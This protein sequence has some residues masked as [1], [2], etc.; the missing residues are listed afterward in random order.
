MR[1]KEIEGIEADIVFRS[2]NNPDIKREHLFEYISNMNKVELIDYIQNISNQ[3]NGIFV[4][5]ENLKK[6]LEILANRN[7]RQYESNNK[8]LGALEFSN[9]GTWELDIETKII[10]LSDISSRIYG[11]KNPVN[12]LTI[13]QA[14]ELVNPQDKYENYVHLTNLIDNDIPYLRDFRIT[15]VSD[16]NERWIRAKGGLIRNLSGKPEKVIGTL[17]DIT[18]S[19]LL[20]HALEES[21]ERH[22]IISELTSDFIYSINNFDSDNPEFEW[23]NKGL[24][25]IYGY[26]KTDLESVGNLEKIVVNHDKEIYR[27][28]FRILNNGKETV[29]EYRVLDNSG[30]LRWVRDYSKPVYNSSENKIVKVIGAIQDITKMKQAEQAIRD[31]HLRLR[32]IFD[33]IPGSICVVD[34]DTII[35]DVN[36]NFLSMQGFNFRNDLIGKKFRDVFRSQM[37]DTELL[38]LEEVINTGNPVTRISV[39]NE[40]IGNCCTY[41]IYTNPVV[42]DFNQV[43]GA[44]KVYTD[45]SDMKTVETKLIKLIDELSE[46]KRTIETQ[47]KEINLINSQLIDSQDRLKQLNSDKDKLFSIIAHDLRNPISSFLN[48]TYFLFTEHE[49][50]SV[51]EIKDLTENLHSSA[52]YLNKLLEN[53]LDWS[54]AQTGGIEFKPVCFNLNEIIFDNLFLFKKAAEEKNIVIAADYAEKPMVFADY[55]MIDTV[56]RNLISNSI[57]FTNPGGNINIR[58]SEID[59][60]ILLE[61]ND[62]GVGMNKQMKKNLFTLEKSSSQTG[63]A[64]EKG[65]GLGLMLVKEFIK[66]HNSELIVDSTEGKGST[67]S[68][69]LSKYMG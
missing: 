69:K 54:R 34:N 44:I 10:Y 28:R 48:Y 35:I 20:R 55:N 67:F 53:L 52:K 43:I 59:N 66:F 30:N 68:F 18:N 5:N 61:V 8:I 12:Q 49:N 50:L 23:L 33:T 16:G 3:L 65:T 2:R 39:E 64:N 7:D 37:L 62:D 58:I 46:S 17:I 38:S 15:R 41:K 25:Y 24:M 47:L 9:I 14:Q 13:E 31:S 11:Y 45:I 63:T 29:T 56:T 26:K 4:E 60:S 32:S 27:K 36:Y 42:D 22:R 1:I 21:E 57:K 40:I 6:E 51:N 19:R